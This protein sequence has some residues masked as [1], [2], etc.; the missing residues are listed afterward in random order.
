M[1]RIV[2]RKIVDRASGGGAGCQHQ[3]GIREV[4]GG[5]T[6]QQF[7]AIDPAGGRLGWYGLPI[8]MD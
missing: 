7:S 5:G 8:F 2:P 3:H 1:G 6:R 4:G